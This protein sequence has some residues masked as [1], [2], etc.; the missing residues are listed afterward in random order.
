MKYW[1][2]SRL[3]HRWINLF[4]V[5]ADAIGMCGLWVLPLSRYRMAWFAF[6]AW[7]MG[8]NGTYWIDKSLTGP[9]K[10]EKPPEC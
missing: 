1:N 3:C 2:N 7:Q 9:T 4:C 10:A 8:V 6:L 5:I